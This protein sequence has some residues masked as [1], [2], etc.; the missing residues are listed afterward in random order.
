MAQIE[1][2]MQQDD[3]ALADR[4]KFGRQRIVEE[5]KKLIIGQDEVV[6]QALLNVNFASYNKAG[7]AAIGQESWDYW[8]TYDFPEYSSAALSDLQW[9][10]YSGGSDVGIVVSNAPGVGSHSLIEDG[11][12]NAFVYGSTSARLTVTI[13]NLTSGYQRSYRLGRWASPSKPLV[14]GKQKRSRART[15]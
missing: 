15:R 4:M 7:P 2:D 11:M 13:T 14:P 9:S 1:Q 3:V 6:N 8:N 10:D 5:L 12:Y